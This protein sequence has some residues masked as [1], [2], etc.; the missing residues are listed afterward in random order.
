MVL[1]DSHRSCVQTFETFQAFDDLTVAT[2]SSGQEAFPV[3]IWQI[4][5]HLLAW[6]AHQLTQLRSGTLAQAFDEQSSWNSERVPP[7]PAAL[8]AAVTQFKQQLVELK[9]HANQAQGELLLVLEQVLQAAAL[10]LFFHLGR[11]YC[12]VGCR[13]RIPGQRRGGPSGKDKK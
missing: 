4:L 2:S 8:Q 12:C 11:S 3:S 10:H 13:A 6:Q 7:N 1:L 9:N 5:Q